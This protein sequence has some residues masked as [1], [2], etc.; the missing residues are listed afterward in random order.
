MMERN[1]MF[2]N[3]Y[4]FSC[5]FF[6]INKEFCTIPLFAVIISISFEIFIIFM[7]RTLERKT[8]SDKI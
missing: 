5:L 1:V 6:K 7:G 4:I 3:V 2:G 8:K